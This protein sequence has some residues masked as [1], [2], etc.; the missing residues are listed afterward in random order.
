[1]DRSLIKI[2]K[3]CSTTATTN[4]C[5]YVLESSWNSSF[6]GRVTF[7]QHQLFSQIIFCRSVSDW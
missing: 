2:S 4:K 7:L 3:A 6:S 5:W 1:M